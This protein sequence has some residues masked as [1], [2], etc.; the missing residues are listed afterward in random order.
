MALFVAALVAVVFVFPRL[1]SGSPQAAAPEVGL[2]AAHH[3]AWGQIR[4]STTY[5][6]LL[7]IV[8]RGVQ[9]S[10][11]TPFGVE[12]WNANDPILDR[13]RAMDN[14]WV[15]LR[16]YWSEIEIVNTIPLYYN[17]PAELD[18]KLARLAA[19]DIHVILTVMGNPFSAA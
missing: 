3:P 12:S 6:S 11:D 1:V 9:S 7:P 2:P 16:L 19:N 17:W 5:T 18:A 14:R 10:V 13:M 4:A 15:R 8:L